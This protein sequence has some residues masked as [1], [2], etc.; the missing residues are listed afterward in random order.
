MASNSKTVDLSLMGAVT[1]N[2]QKRTT[3]TICKLVSEA[4]TKSLASANVSNEESIGKLCQDMVKNLAVT[5]K[6]P[7]DEIEDEL[8]AEWEEFKQNQPTRD[9]GEVNQLVARIEE[10]RVTLLNKEELSIEIE[11]FNRNLGGPSAIFQDTNGLP[12][13]GEF[14]KFPSV[15]EFMA[16]WT[17][18]PITANGPDGTARTPE[19]IE[20]LT[21]QVDDEKENIRAS[22]TALKDQWERMAPLVSHNEGMVGRMQH[23]YKRTVRDYMSPVKHFVKKHSFQ[24]TKPI[25]DHPDGSKVYTPVNGAIE[26]LIFRGN[27]R[28]EEDVS[29]C[30]VVDPI[31]KTVNLQESIKNMF[32]LASRK[33]YTVDRHMSYFFKTFL[34]RF[35]PNQASLHEDNYFADSLF[36]II[37]TQ[38]TPQQDL[39]KAKY[40]LNTLKR[41]AGETIRSF[42][43]RC[44][45]V[46][47]KVFSLTKSPSQR[48]AEQ[49]EI[50]TRAERATKHFIIQ[51]TKPNISALVRSEL[52]QA[53]SE[54]EEPSLEEIMKRI[55]QLEV[56]DNKPS[57]NEEFNPPKGDVNVYT[58]NIR[59]GI[60]IP[61]GPLGQPGHQMDNSTSNS[62]KASVNAGEIN[63]ID[64]I[65]IDTFG[66]MKDDETVVDIEEVNVHYTTSD[67][68][69]F[70]IPKYRNKKFGNVSGNNAFRSNRG[71]DRRGDRRD[72]N[73]SSGGS[74][75]SNNSSRYGRLR[76]RRDN[77]PAAQRTPSMDRNSAS[78]N[79]LKDP[80]VVAKMHK[81][82]TSCLRCYSGSHVT[83]ACPTYKFTARTP[84]NCKQGYHYI[85]DGEAKQSCQTVA[86]NTR[87][88][89][90]QLARTD[91]RER[92]DRRS[93][94]RSSSYDSRRRSGDRRSDRR[95]RSRSGELVLFNKRTNKPFNTARKVHVT[96]AR[97]YGRRSRSNSSARSGSRDRRKSRDRT[98]SGD[99]RRRDTRRSTRR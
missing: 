49:E 26:T 28:Y 18:R 83:M 93:R 90:G 33:G 64:D 56:G 9:A 79:P 35:Y 39:K 55:E 27:A 31:I 50:W 19:E 98:K 68:K 87:G 37:L 78:Y 23:L 66:I 8:K 52:D 53:T 2:Q 96:R 45:T 7:E 67:G 20:R 74:G 91:S 38:N 5:Q 14:D 76:G 69:S 77:S 94:S 86:Y 75:S 89:G 48:L 58:A 72:S 47:K 51:Y 70:M 25:T 97:S 17:F 24:N 12:F 11:K 6:R 92:R 99:R 71:S 42:A 57:P 60:E 54:Y 15:D 80:E 30:A 43:D 88:R 3:E 34:K 16:T 95:S 46:Q 61:F 84:C 32:R 59:K 82:G 21:D 65:D 40:H 81:F 85:P 63:S 22:Y 73:R 13:P 44:L 36:K 29:E 4:I 62:S 41:V 1:Y 10:A